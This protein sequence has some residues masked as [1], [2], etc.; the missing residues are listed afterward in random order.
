MDWPPD[1]IEVSFSD[2]IAAF[3]LVDGQN[4]DGR[5]HRPASEILGL[6]GCT[7]KGARARPV[8]SSCVVLVRLT[9]ATLAAIFLVT[10]SCKGQK[11]FELGHPL[12]QFFSTRDY[13]GDNQ[14]WSAI[15]D[16]N[17][18]LFFGN[19]NYVLDY[20]GQ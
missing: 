4:F 17:G 20:D 2:R 9:L 10:Q 6:P 14:N 19:N 11:Y 3:D 16:R 5:E 7:H 13:G 12:Y 8:T 1:Q 18:L 15:Q